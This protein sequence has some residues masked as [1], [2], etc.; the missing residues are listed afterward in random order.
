MKIYSKKVLT[1]ITRNIE[2]SVHVH[3]I[4]DTFAV[5]C[6]DY[7]QGLLLMYLSQQYVR[8]GDWQHSQSI[9]VN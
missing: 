6:V 5:T 2:F 1:S 4:Y 9:D 3:L 7:L 8:F